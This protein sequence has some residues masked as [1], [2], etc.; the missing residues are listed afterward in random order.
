MNAM[1]KDFVLQN[2]GSYDDWLIEQLRDPKEALT[3][4]EAALEAYEEDSDATALLFALR[5]VANAQDCIGQLT[6]RTG[7]SQEALDE[8][9]AGKHSAQLNNLPA[10]LSSLG[11]RIRLERV[12]SVSVPAAIL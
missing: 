8:A 11:F 3:Y 7:I 12:G 6:K 2:T 5:S 4:L 1:N 10:I 9:Q